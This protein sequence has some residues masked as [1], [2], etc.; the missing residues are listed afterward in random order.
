[1]ATS[2]P[3][4]RDK[5]RRA[6]SLS[7]VTRRY[8]DAPRDKWHTKPRIKVQWE[9]NKAINLGQQPKNFPPLIKS[10]EFGYIME[11]FIRRLMNVPSM[12]KLNKEEAIELLFG[13]KERDIIPCYAAVGFKIEGL[14]KE[15]GVHR[16]PLKQE[17]EVRK[18]E[19][20][21][22]RID[23][24]TPNRI[25]IQRPTYKKN[26][27]LTFLLTPLQF[28]Y[29]VNRVNV[30]ANDNKRLRMRSRK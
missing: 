1:M 30:I 13:I 7:D 8:Q 4:R 15:P 24:R 2:N 25:D 21:F 6:K 19:A 14:V 27:D 11:L 26:P 17:C 20:L 3:K 9:A 16:P 18:G 22:I 28:D 5:R 10:T 29:I 23:E 12:L